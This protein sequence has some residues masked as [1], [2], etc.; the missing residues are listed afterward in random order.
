[1]EA[2]FYVSGAVLIAATALAV[3]CRH[4]LHALL[5]FLVSLF[6]T[7][8]IFYILGAPFVA[9]LE[10][11]IYA[12]AIIV[13]YVFVVMILGLGPEALGGVRTPAGVRA[14]IGPGVLGGILAAELGYVVL[15]GGPAAGDAAG[16][17]VSP[18]EVGRRL[19]G[20]YLLGVELA[21]LLLLAAL[22]G[23]FH[24]ARPDERSRDEVSD[25]ERARRARPA[26][27]G[28]RVPSGTGRSASTS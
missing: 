3:T 14:W 16:V 18:A 19:F 5:Y 27:G 10:I 26:P 6:A 23:A 4:V 24:L 28:D 2:I 11:I 12:G 20:T 1:M 15:A 25:D 21:S 7:A 22:V 8:V 9:A 17:V 13:L